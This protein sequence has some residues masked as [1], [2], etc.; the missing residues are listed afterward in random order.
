MR[1]LKTTVALLLLLFF[2]FYIAYAYFLRSGGINEI[3]WHIEYGDKWVCKS[4]AVLVDN[5]PLS[6]YAQK[7]MWRRYSDVLLHKAPLLTSGCDTIVFLRNKTER[8]K[9]IGDTDYWIDD[10]QYCLNSAF[11]NKKCISKE[12]Q[13]FVIQLR[14]SAEGDEKIGYIG[15]QPVYIHF[16]TF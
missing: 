16:I 9:D 8:A 7:K 2:V 3:Y 11:G 5:A 13:L 14:P 15:K 12:E 10:Y 4:T 6:R 1:H